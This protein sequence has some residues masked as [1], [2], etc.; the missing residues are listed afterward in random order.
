MT[1]TVLAMLCFGQVA[2]AGSMFP[3][4]T[5]AR[6]AFSTNEIKLPMVS[7]FGWSKVDAAFDCHFYAN[8][9]Y[10][11]NVSFGGFVHRDGTVIGGESAAVHVNGIS[12]PVGG[13]SV[14][15]FWSTKATPNNGIDVPMKIGF[16]FTDLSKHTGGAYSGEITFTVFGS[17]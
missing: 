17:S 1:A 12:V 4:E 14:P 7:P 6:I 16:S 10:Q 13:H 2:F 3:A 9:P 8:C 11:V 5:C 15:L